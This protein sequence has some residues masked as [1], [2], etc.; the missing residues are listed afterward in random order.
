MKL[1]DICRQIGVHKSKGHSIL[2][3]LGQFDFIEKD[4]QT[5]FYSLGPGLLSLSRNLLDNL[6]YPEVAAPFL[7]NLADETN[8][9]AVFGLVH[10]DHVFVVG[11]HEG[12]QYVGFTLRL[13]HRFHITLGAH[14]KAI[15][16]FMPEEDRERILAKRRLH[17]HGEGAS[18]LDMRQVKK[19]LDKCRQLGFAQD[20]GEVSSGLNVVSAPVFGLRDKIVGCIILLGTFPETVAPEYGSRVAGVAR[21]ISTR[22]GAKAE[23]IY[24]C[25]STDHEVPSCLPAGRNAK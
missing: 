15:M 21:Q 12:N 9:T 24:P 7:Q 10:G 6:I 14:G 5:K 4:P 20:M 22:L 23:A 18:R 1:S 8:A 11:K 3:T 13:G 16:A 17:S 19:E 2:N 25:T